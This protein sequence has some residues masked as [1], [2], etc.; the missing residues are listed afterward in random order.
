LN[1]QEH[2][3]GH[4]NLLILKQGIIEPSYQTYRYL[5]NLSPNWWGNEHNQI[6]ENA[7]HLET[8]HLEKERRKGAIRHRVFR[9]Y[10]SAYLSESLIIDLLN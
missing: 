6:Q 2:H 8:G 3:L 5:T 4:K 1:I 7:G 9:L 10:R